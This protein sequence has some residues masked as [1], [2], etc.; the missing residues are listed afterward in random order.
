M[1]MVL[2]F[3]FVYATN[4]QKTT[5]PYVALVARVWQTSAQ[6]AYAF[7]LLNCVQFHSVNTHFILSYV[8]CA[9]D[10]TGWQERK[11]GLIRESRA[12]FVQ[13]SCLVCASR[14]LVFFFTYSDDY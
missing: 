5:I 11:I 13:S 10:G 9:M 2:N 12:L 14:G 1:M 8:G 3:N 7:C 6:I 4:T